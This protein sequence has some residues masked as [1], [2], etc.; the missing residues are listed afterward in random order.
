MAQADARSLEEIKRDTERARAGLTQTVDELKT[1]VSETANDFRERISPDAIKAEVSGYIKSRGEAMIESVTEAA[2]QNPLQAVAIG[3][4]IA[5]PL[6]RLIRTIPAPV[7]MVGAGLYLAGTKKGQ[8]VTRQATDAASEFAD[9]AMRR[10]RELRH[11]VEDAAAAGV[12]YAA[13][14]LD[15]ASDAVASGTAQV[16]DTASAI[17]ASVAATADGIRRQVT[18]AGAA[19]AD[20]AGEIAGRAGALAQTGAEISGAAKGNARDMVSEMASSGRQAVGA[21][22]DAGRD[23]VNSTVGAGRN[24]LHATTEAGRD[25][26]HAATEAGR[27]AIHAGKDALH[28][29]RHRAAELG[30]DASKTFVEAVSKNPLL[31]AGIGLVVGGLIASAL[32]RSDIEDG[33]MGKASSGVKKRARATVDEGID[34]A[35]ATAAGIVEDVKARV[36]E[37]GLSA[38]SLSA[39][40]KDI[41]ERVRKV[42]DA[43]VSSVDTA[44]QN[45]H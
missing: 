32:P 17:G 20:R 7:L 27:D 34:Q 31:V 3:A 39:T 45:K 5:F 1:T 42:A 15:A 11:D 18:G 4:G 19:V 30:N 40:A 41:G 10:A 6:L 8:E 16:K 14:R 38:E 44:S 26:L 2:R 24:A 29:A 37:E 36:E 12:G 22:A 9:D 23:A 25:A 13:N 33:V 21:T 35:K 43:G 28:T